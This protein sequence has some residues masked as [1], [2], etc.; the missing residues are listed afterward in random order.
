M[1]DHRPLSSICRSLVAAVVAVPLLAAPLTAQQSGDEVV[2]G[3]VESEAG[4]PIAAAVVT[5][6][7]QATAERYS[8]ETSEDGS[9]RIARLPAGAY[10]LE[11][12]ATGYRDLTRPRL[13]VPSERAGSLQLELGISPFEVRDIRAAVPGSRVEQEFRESYGR[14]K[15]ETSLSARTTETFNTANN[16]DALRMVPG[17]NFIRGAGSRF[18]SPSRIRGASTWT[19]PDVIEDLPAVNASGV[20][21]EDGGLTAGVG[22]T[23][24]SVA[25]RQVQ[26]KKGD[27]GVMYG[28]NVDGGVIRNQIKRG[29]PG[30][31]RA[32]LYAETSRADEGLFMGDVGGGTE[33]VDYYVAGKALLGEYDQYRDTFQ[34][35]L[36]E[37]RF[38]SG[39][40]R[41]GVNPSDDLRFEGMALLGRDRIRYTQ[42][43]DDDPETVPDESVTEPPNRFRTTN[44][45]GYY[46]F[47]VDHDATEAFGWEA[48]FTLHDVKAVRFSITEDRAH[49]DRPQRTETFFANAY[50]QSELADGVDYAGR[51]GAE[52]S[53]HRQQENAFGSDKDQSFTDRSVFLANSVT[54]DGRLTLEA[55]LRALDA[56]DDWADHTA[57]AHDLGAS[58]LFPATDTRL[59]ISHST[60]YSRN[61]GFA[62][63]FGPIEEAGGVGLSHNS[64]LE[65]GVEQ[66]L[67]TPTSRDGSISVTAFR[68]DNDDVPIFSGWGAGEVYTETREVQGL[69]VMTRYPLL[70]QLGVMASFSAMDTEVVSTTDPSGAGVGSTAVPLPRYTGALG[71]S[72]DPTDRLQ[73]TLLGTYNDGSRQETVDTQTGEVTVTT[74]EA[75]TRV[76]LNSRYELWGGLSARLRVENLLDQTDLGFS[77]KTINPDGSTSTSDPGA[78]VPGRFVSVGLSWSY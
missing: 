73:V 74:R 11:V 17:V 33:S 70:R 76:N 31:T 26:V 16:Y 50:V 7:R 27:L 58:Y 68:R 75:Y 66:T 35:S 20:G 63:F 9:F 19:I 55:G 64:T 59:R 40:A 57:L 25:I 8:A 37:E 23:I 3:V 49:R 52:H 21:T 51:L 53:H 32:S 34:R 43:R 61:R 41:V 42:P 10:R 6:V 2:A 54:V 44:R 14:A 22:T 71:F 39:L 65:A 72:A 38:Y 13:E 18:A 29:R 24:P 60:S 69:E 30:N 15:A 4:E 77:T 28:G 48:G 36:N 78:R 1:P 67:P 12:R 47:T 45:N 62:Y 56:E 5:L 46:A